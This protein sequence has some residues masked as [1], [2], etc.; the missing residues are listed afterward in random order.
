VAAL[1]PGSVVAPDLPGRNGKSWD[2]MTLTVAEGAASLEAEVP[3]D[4]SYVVAAHSSGGLFVPRLV[5]RL[6][7][8]RV[9]SIVL[10]AASVP[11]E[12]G[13]GLE[14]MKERHR[15]GIEHLVAQARRDGV[16]IT[17]PVAEAEAMR[18]SSGEELD[19][20][21]LEFIT[22]PERLVPDSLNV[23][24]HPVHWSSVSSVPVTYIVSTLD[25]AVPPD[26][27]REMAAR[28]KNLAS[29]VELPIGH[30]GAVTAPDVLAAT[31]ARA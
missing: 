21:Q 5:E 22:S 26:L 28:L 9:R 8:D 23:Y 12:G 20:E 7:V 10:Y 19:D 24:F 31:I 29:V 16:V 30:Y 3:P 11:T 25:R 6:G 15:A 1:L 17:T 4:A 18:T 13:M 14:C 2:P 27:Q